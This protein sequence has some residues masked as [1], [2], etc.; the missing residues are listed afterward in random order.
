MLDVV[1]G[2]IAGLNTSLFYDF[3][4]RKEGLGTTETYFV[5]SG[6]MEEQ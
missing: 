4:F 2:K 6:E 3:A 5:G 1:A